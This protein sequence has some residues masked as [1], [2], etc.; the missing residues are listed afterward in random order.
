MALSC[1][2][3]SKLLILKLF[4]SH[5]AALYCDTKSTWINFPHS[6]ICTHQAVQVCHILYA[7]CFLPTLDVF[8]EKASCITIICL[9]KDRQE[10]LW[11]LTFSDRFREVFEF[12]LTRFLNGT[13]LY[14][15]LKTL[16]FKII[17]KSWDNFLF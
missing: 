2:I 3:F 15:I 1:T 9:D 14:N 5:S 16:D 11:L 12:Y 13:E 17:P 10:Y 8:M 4:Q 6:L 7:G